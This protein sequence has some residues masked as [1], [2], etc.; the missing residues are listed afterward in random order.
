MPCPSCNIYGTW[1]SREVGGNFYIHHEG[2]IGSKH[3]R[4]NHFLLGGS[5][6]LKALVVGNKSDLDKIPKTL[7]Y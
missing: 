4:R 3:T 2:R 6:K 5:C 7:K 1:R